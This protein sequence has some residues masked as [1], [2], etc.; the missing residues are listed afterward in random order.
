MTSE[1]WI[2]AVL[3]AHVTIIALYWG[4]MADA[5]DTRVA[6]GAGVVVV[7]GSGDHDEDASARG[8]ARV[9]GTWAL[10]IARHPLIRDTCASGV[11]GLTSGASVLI[12]TWVARHVLVDTPL[13]QD[14]CVRGA[15]V[16]IVAGVGG[17]SYATAEVTGVVNRTGIIVVTWQHLK[18]KMLALAL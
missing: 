4:T 5:Q 8:V 17:C 3:S 9:Y 15:R 11:A 10:V 13:R 18:A 1:D 12:I 7:T 6:V 16:S 2:A 14:A